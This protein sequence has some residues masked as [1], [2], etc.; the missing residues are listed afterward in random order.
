MPRT[1]THEKRHQSTEWYRVGIEVHPEG[2]HVRLSLIRVFASY[3]VDV[4]VS[5]S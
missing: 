4:L 3:T 2:G 1:Y 5:Y